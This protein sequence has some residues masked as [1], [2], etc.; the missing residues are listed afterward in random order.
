MN[1]SKSSRSRLTPAQQSEGLMFVLLNLY[2]DYD[3]RE[4]VNPDL[5]AARSRALAAVASSFGF[6]PDQTQLDIINKA[7]KQ[8]FLHFYSNWIIN[9]T[10]FDR[11]NLTLYIKLVY[12]L[13]VI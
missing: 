11:N 3:L 5:P 4:S 6:T 7:D 13:V 9:N 8:S 12:M 10:V 1:S 2:V